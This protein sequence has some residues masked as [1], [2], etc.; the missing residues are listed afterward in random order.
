MGL[1]DKR[2]KKNRA[3]SPG[4]PSW[5]LGCDYS[6]GGRV[7]ST[8]GLGSA[9]SPTRQNLLPT[10]VSSRLVWSTCKRHTSL[11]LMEYFTEEM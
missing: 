5:P 3:G 8:D 10:R 4:F 2:K 1:S 7:E 9:G 11:K 6:H